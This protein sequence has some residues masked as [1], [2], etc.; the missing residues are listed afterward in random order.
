MPRYGNS[1]KGTYNNKYFMRSSNELLF[2]LIC[3]YWQD[4]KYISEWTFESLNFELKD[5]KTDEIYKTGRKSYL[6]DFWIQINK[7]K[8]KIAYTLFKTAK[9][10]ILIEIKGQVNEKG[11]NG[12]FSEQDLKDRK[13]IQLRDS[14]DRTKLS[15]LFKDNYYSNEIKV[16]TDFYVISGKWFKENIDL[17]EKAFKKFKHRL[18]EKLFK[19]KSNTIFHKL[20]LIT[21]V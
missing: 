7:R 6:N 4:Q 3:D 18:P 16:N 13:F 14:K 21:H 15:R 9:K 20:G 19:T 1:F 17:C 2:A 10:H 8:K 12:I 11:A 5:P